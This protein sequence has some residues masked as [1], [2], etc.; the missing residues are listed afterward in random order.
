LA[1]VRRCRSSPTRLALTGRVGDWRAGSSP[2]HAQAVARGAPSLRPRC[3]RWAHDMA[4]DA[5][6]CS[7]SVIL[8]YLFSSPLPC[9]NGLDRDSPGC[10]AP[11]KRLTHVKPTMTRAAPGAR[12]WRRFP[13][14]MASS[15]QRCKSRNSNSGYFGPSMAG[16]KTGYRNDVGVQ[17]DSWLNPDHEAEVMAVW[18]RAWTTFGCISLIFS[19]WNRLDIQPQSAAGQLRVG[20]AYKRGAAQRFSSGT[21]A[22]PSRVGRTRLSPNRREQLSRQ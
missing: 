20:R 19:C 18:S 2:T 12:T 1:K 15:R 4:T 13:A 16:S 8:F 5:S 11:G 21:G 14:L 17:G 7:V 10:R 9:G 6:A 22:A 3:R